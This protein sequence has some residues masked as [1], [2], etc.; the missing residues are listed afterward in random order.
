MTGI[1]ADELITKGI[2]DIQT[3]FKQ[4]TEAVISVR[5]KDRCV[6]MDVVRYTTF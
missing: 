1:S 4:Q 2:S 6:V 5:G 3:A